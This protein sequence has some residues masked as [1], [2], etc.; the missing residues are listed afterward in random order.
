MNNGLHAN[1]PAGP[2]ENR[3]TRHCFDMALVNPANRKKYKVIV[4]APDWRVVRPQPHSVS[5]A[6]R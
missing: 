2:L 6:I 3:W 4:V 5:W 1:E